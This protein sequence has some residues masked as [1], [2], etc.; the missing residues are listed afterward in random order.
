MITEILTVGTEILLGNI[1]NANAA[2]LSRELAG[3]GVSVFRHTSVGDNHKRL[4][5]AFANAFEKADVVITTG[6]LGPTQDD[7]TKGVAA[8]YFGLELEMHEESRQRIITRFAGRTLPESVERNALVPQGATVFPNENGSAPGICIESGGKIL[9]MLPGPPHEMQPMFLNHAAA[10]LRGKTDGV[11]V[12]R[13]LKIIGIGETAVETRLQDLIDAQTNPTIAPY[14]KVGEVHVRLTASALNETAAHDLLSPVADEIYS[15]LSPQIYGEDE[16]SL[17]EIVIAM[18]KAKN[19]TVA[20]A[21]SCTGGLVSADLV[22]VA[23][24]SSVFLEGFTTYSNEAKIA[25]LSVSP[26]LLETH[27]AV[28]PEVAAAMAEGAAKA[29][30]ATVGISTTG[31]AGPDGG[32][33]SKPV[34][35]VY[36]GLFIAGRETIT[37]KFNTI[38]NRAEV[39]CR[40][41]MLALDFLRRNLPLDNPPTEC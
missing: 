32:T 36:V 11:F 38:G 22:S 27:G 8:E 31:I 35:L 28:S 4:K 1:V 10:F 33:E 20:V 37:A 18:L 7:I 41:T 24:C 39:R 13:T 2:F 12:S 15:R 40:S 30:N 25:R 29:A 23:G 19:Q 5:N 3:I 34:G 14:A 17:A 21:E 9:I 6:G 16:T 26:S